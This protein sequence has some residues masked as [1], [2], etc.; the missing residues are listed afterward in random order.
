[1]G[2]VDP[3]WAEINSTAFY[4]GSR[5]RKTNVGTLMVR[6]D[7]TDAVGF[8]QES[9]S[10]REAFRQLL[11]RWISSIRLQERKIHGPIRKEL[12][13]VLSQHRAALTTDVSIKTRAPILFPVVALPEGYNLERTEEVASIT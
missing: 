1:M 7:V 12:V 6:K 11:G 5:R 8:L 13:C 3:V 4:K 2:M 9:L 10:T